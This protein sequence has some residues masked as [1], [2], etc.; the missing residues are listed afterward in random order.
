MSDP[1]RALEIIHS[2]FGEHAGYRALHAKGRLYEAE[3][4]ATS[5]AGELTRAAHMSGE[6]VGALVRLSN[7]AGDPR[8]PDYEPDVRGM[9][10]SFELPDGSRTD[11]SSQ[12]L[13]RFPFSGVE[14]F[15]EFVRLS[16]PSLAAAARLPL[17]ALRNPGALWPLAANLPTLRPPP[18][19]AACAFYAIHAF[20]WT[21]ADGGSRH[22]RY[23]WRPT[24]ELP[25]LSRGEARRL[26][27][28][29]LFEEME[30]RLAAGTVRF[31]L[32]LQVAGPGDD[33][34]DPSAVWPAERRRVVAGTLEI[35]EPT[36]RGDGDVFD[37][38]RVTDG[39][40]ASD[41]PVL[42]FRPRAYSVSHALRA[43]AE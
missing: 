18:S 24:V 9:A 12:S 35:R 16:R 41:D 27:R 31:E 26:G 25:Q 40:E 7:G 6:R 37:P 17:F 5:E 21:D 32:E 2:R 19:F 38:T 8:V 43:S 10:V 4:R 15:L 14:P 20:R 39:I 33:P 36:D 3:F 1:E 28:D 13:P 42:A 22:V 34:D 29:Y 30:R 23:T 11:I